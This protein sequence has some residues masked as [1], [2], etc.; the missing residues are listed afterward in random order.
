[1]SEKIELVCTPS[2]IKFKK[3]TKPQIDELWNHFKFVDNDKKNKPKRNKYQDIH[4]RAINR[5]VKLMGIG[6]LDYLIAYMHEKEFDYEIFETR[7]FGILEDESK[8]DE[9]DLKNMFDVMEA[10][11]YQIDAVRSALKAKHGIIKSGTGTGKSL[12]IAMLTKAID[13]P[14]LIMFNRTSLVVKTY[15]E[16]LA[17][18]FDQKDL[19]IIS[20][21]INKPSRINFCTV[22]SKDKIYDIIEHFKLVIVDECHGMKSPSFQEFMAVS[23]A[24]WRFGFSAT[25]F[26][27]NPADKA[28]VVNFTG[29]IVYK[30]AKTVDMIE[31]GVL[32]KPSVFFIDCNRESEGEKIWNPS[33]K[34]YR[35]LLRTEIVENE[36]RNGIVVDLC[37]IKHDKKIVILFEMIKHGDILF[38]MISKKF[39]DKRKVV[40]LHGMNTVN[41]RESNLHLFEHSSNDIIIASRIFDEGVDIKT[42]DV[43]INTSAGKSF[44]R[45]IQRL[46]RGLR[47]GFKG[48][49]KQSEYFDF[50]DLNSRVMLKHS[51]KRMDVYKKEGHNVKRIN[52]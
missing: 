34:D 31:R 14:A 42:V 40:M 43:V 13:L 19:G 28:K 33:G 30:G 45:S 26:N 36:Y 16:F 22:Q 8:V 2:F 44:I 37:E 48:E 32:A 52:L 6:F 12:M 41:E 4:Y 7:E 10:R 47:M 50:V 29:R 20:G 46:G 49:K 5:K 38:D 35:E 3:I 11:D 39:G 24:P 18:G 9:I 17:L 23:N 21:D 51:K 25:P 1:M 27:D 15:K